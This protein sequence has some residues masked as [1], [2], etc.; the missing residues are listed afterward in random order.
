MDKKE[1]EEEG[2]FFPY[3]EKRNQKVTKALFR[4][5]QNYNKAEENF[6]SAIN[7]NV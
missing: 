6:P 1:K 2:I 3:K 4:L 5:L 7:I